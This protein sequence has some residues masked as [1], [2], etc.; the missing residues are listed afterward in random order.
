M[1]NH[2]EEQIKVESSGHVE[3]GCIWPAGGKLL[4]AHR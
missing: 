1:S 4:Q 3:R 2:D